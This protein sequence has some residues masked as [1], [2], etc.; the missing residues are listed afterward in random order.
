MPWT[1]FIWTHQ[2]H[3][4]I[5]F[6]FDSCKFRAEKLWN[7]NSVFIV[8]KCIS[9]DSLN[10]EVFQTT[11]VTGLRRHEN[12]EIS[13]LSSSHQTFQN[14]LSLLARVET[15]SVFFGKFCKHRTTSHAKPTE[16]VVQDQ[17]F[18]NA[19]GLFDSMSSGRV[20]KFTGKENLYKQLGPVSG[21][22]ENASSVHCLKLCELVI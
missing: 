21:S 2:E 20:K 5:I 10:S 14:E 3:I 9:V 16:I 13:M 1:Y 8:W 18:L 17:S 4:K 6:R 19:H 22:H 7:H 11:Q 15:F 12:V